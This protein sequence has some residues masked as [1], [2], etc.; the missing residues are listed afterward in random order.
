ML[1]DCPET[2]QVLSEWTPKFDGMTRLLDLPVFH[3]MTRQEQV[4]VALGEPPPKLLQK[5]IRAWKEEALPLCGEFT[6]SLR[7]H[8]IS[9]Q[10]TPA[11]LTSS[12]ES[13]SSSEDDLEPLEPP[14]GFR[15]APAAPA[16]AELEPLNPNGQTLIGSHILYKWPREGWQHGML[17]KWNDNPQYKIGKKIVNF[18]AHYPCD[19]S[20]PRHVLSLDSYNTEA[21][22]NSP[23][24]TWIMLE[25]HP[26]SAPPA[27]DGAGGG[28]A[29]RSSR[30]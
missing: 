30:N 5:Q 2:K 27:L 28:G 18:M 22:E 1:L 7:S 20:T 6:R 25:P 23:N 15:F 10:R 14:P 8:L 3:S 26:I 11:D 29:G 17:V 12:D 24:H 13:A 19:G 9:I 21:W 4:S 16:Q